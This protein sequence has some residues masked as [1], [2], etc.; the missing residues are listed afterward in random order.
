MTNNVI[1]LKKSTY[2][3]PD[4]EFEA[5]LQ[6]IIN[7]GRKFYDFTCYPAVMRKVLADAL[8]REKRDGDS[9]LPVA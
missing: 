2:L 7:Q 5:L 1:P 9:T 3:L 4:D 6:E 8:K